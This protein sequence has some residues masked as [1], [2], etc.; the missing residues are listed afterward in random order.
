M[1]LI[2]VRRRELHELTRVIKNLDPK[3]FVSVTS[4]STVYG[5]GFEEIKTGVNLKLKKSQNNG[6]DAE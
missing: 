5:E 2:L 3:A 6:Q 4:A 1:L